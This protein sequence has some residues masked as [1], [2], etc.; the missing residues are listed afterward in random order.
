MSVKGAFV[1]ANWLD[2]ATATGTTE[3]EEVTGASKYGL[4]VAITGGPSAVTVRLQ[5]S[6]DGTGWADI[7]SYSATSDGTT[8]IVDKP[9]RYA[10]LN[11]STLTGGSSPTVTASVIAV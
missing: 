9:V 6:I 1:R 7:G 5:G 8:F 10:R 11:L 3:A 4:Q 2:V